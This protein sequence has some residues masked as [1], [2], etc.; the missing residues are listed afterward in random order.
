MTEWVIA[1]DWRPNICSTVGG[2][3][4][5]ITFYVGTLATCAFS[6]PL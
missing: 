4:A 5:L 2:L 3:T 6:L 1:A